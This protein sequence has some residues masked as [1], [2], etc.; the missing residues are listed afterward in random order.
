MK[1]N[2]DTTQ[3]HIPR[4]IQTDD[5]LHLND[6]ILWFD[7]Q[8]PGGLTFLSS[9]DTIF[10]QQYH[11]QIITTAET[12]KLLESCGFS[13]PINALVCQY[14]RSFS[15]GKLKI[16]LLPSGHVL[17][18]ASLFVETQSR[19]ILYAPTLQPSAISTV[20]RMQLKRADTLIL[21]CFQS[22]PSTKPSR[23]KEKE[24]LIETVNS[25]IARGQYP[26]I[27]CPSLTSAPELTKLFSEH[28]IATAVHS[29]IFK[30]NRVYENY[31]S[32]LGT[33]TLYSRKYT[34]NKVIIFP[35]Y[36]HKLN[37][38]RKPLPAGPIFI[39]ED[40]I[41][42]NSSTGE[43]LRHSEEDFSLTSLADGIELK[44]IIAAIK[45]Q[46]TLLFGP[47]VKRY[48]KIIEGLCEIDTLDMNNQPSL[49]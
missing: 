25:Y 37:R 48:A 35:M 8:T 27:L 3:T 33:Y 29:S 18:G 28:D 49:F 26:I 45:P 34:R 9:A 16:E 46:K 31:G 13:N 11:S 22:D 14:N 5:G 21:G 2:F 43:A 7:S 20:R 24:R 17:G 47:Y 23:K 40:G 44:E 41:Y 4:V 1:E 39:V 15:I 6:S 19:K 32:K 10:A 42:S 12:I 36:D 30:I 38:L